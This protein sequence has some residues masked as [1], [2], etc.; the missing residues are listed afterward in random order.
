MYINN[1]KSKIALRTWVTTRIVISG[2]PGIK[3]K[4]ALNTVI[5]PKVK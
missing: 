2:A 4:V 1:G 3:I 5:K